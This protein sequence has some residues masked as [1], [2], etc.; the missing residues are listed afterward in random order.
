MNKKVYCLGGTNIDVVMSTIRMPEKGE[1]ALGENHFINQG[2]KGANQAI[3]LKKLGADVVLISAIGDDYFGKKIINSLREYDVSCQNVKIIKGART[4][5]ALIILEKSTNDN[6][7][8]VDV[9]AN[10]LLDFN[11]VKVA[12]S[13]AKKDDLFVSQLEVKCDV[14]KKSL[15]EAKKI[16]LKTILN[17]APIDKEILGSL[18]Y[19]DLLITNE[20]EI[21]ALT[22]VNVFDL[23]TAKTAYA[24]LCNKGLKELIVTLGEKGS[25]YVGMSSYFIPAI[26]VDAVDTT[27]AGD[28]Y[29]GALIVQLSE[30]NDMKKAML[31]A[32]KCSALTV[33]KEGAGISIP[34]KE[35]I[36]DFMK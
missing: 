35:E 1:S 7:I 24:I 17:P 3:A 16:G 9:G 4:G 30:G 12:L 21:K 10:N 28:A 8:V 34:T 25:I 27:S 14:V 29:I 20:I 31:Y 2:G 6:Y 33:T 23:G 18:Q 22:D 32:T 15:I 5:V 26:K 13:Q 36:D 11:D 19:V